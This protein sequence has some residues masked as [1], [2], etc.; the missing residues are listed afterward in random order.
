MSRQISF[1]DIRL[2]QISDSLPERVAYIDESGGF[3]FDYSKERT[4]KFY[5]LCAIVVEREK[6]PELHEEF[7]KIKYNNGLAKAELKSSSI[8]DIGRRDRIMNQILPL[9]FQIVLLIANKEEF[10]QGTPLTEY[11]H[12]FLK[13]M[14]QHLYNLLYKAYPKCSILQDEKGYPEFQESFRNYVEKNRPRPNLFEIYDFNFVNSKDEILVQLADF[15]GGSITKSLEDSDCTNYRQILRTKIAAHEI[16][17]NKY[18]P[19]WGKLKPEENKYNNAVYGLAM[20]SVNEFISKYNNDKSDERRMQIAVLEYLLYYVLQIDATKFV[21]SDELIEHLRENFGFRISKNVLFRRV[22]A[23][24]RD[25]D[26]ILASSGKG[27]KIPISVE[28]LM[29]YLN[30]T[31]S[32]TGPMMERMGKCRNLIRQGTDLD[33]FDDPAFLKYK[34]YFD[35]K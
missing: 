34:N 7:E 10:K 8:G 12:V 3:G 6:L 26:V 28:D 13:N 30:Q 1:D 14:G 11:E 32:T 18:E 16:F 5:V 22:I 24:I 27:Y 33:L 20:K 17:P 29:A 15:I 25:E 4:S 23:R 19:Y 21:Y 35:I 31:T 9:N 2:Q